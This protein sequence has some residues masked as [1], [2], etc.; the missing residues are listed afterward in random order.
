M[1]MTFDGWMTWVW[2][3][4]A[5]AFL[6][7]WFGFCGVSCLKRVVHCAELLCYFCVASTSC[8]FAVD[9][10]CWWWLSSYM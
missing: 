9:C 7:F 4:T 1:L 5:G 3:Y 2:C 8:F 6:S 10:C